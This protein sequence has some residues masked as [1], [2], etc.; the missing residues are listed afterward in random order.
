MPEESPRLL[1]FGTCLLGSLAPR[2]GLAALRL[3]ALAGARV[4]YP[5]D[6]SCCGQPAYNAGFADQARAV[7]RTQLAA[8]AGKAPIVVPSA[9]CAGMFVHG[10][11]RLFAGTPDEAR[12]RQ[13]AGRVVEFSDWLERHWLP[14]WS[15][16]GPPLRVALHQSCSARREL[17]VA[18]QSRALLERLTRVELVEPEGATECCGFGGTFALKQPDIAAAMTAD[19]ATAL[20]ATGANLLVSQDLGCLTNLDGYLRRQGKA[21]PIMHLA[22]FLWRRITPNG[23]SA[24]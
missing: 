3:L 13:L 11:P 7:A 4:R 16:Q 9:S 6:Q 14:D 15:D 24:P 10:Y 12:A 5:P 23:E 2:A 18:D 19:K 8:L 1:F 21:L 22:E 17:G 20:L